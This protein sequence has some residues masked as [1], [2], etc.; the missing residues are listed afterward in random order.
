MKKQESKY[1]FILGIGLAWLA[2]I[3]LALLWVFDRIDQPKI[4]MMCSAPWQWCVPYTE[5]KEIN[6]IIRQSYL[7]E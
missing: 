3:T 2:I 4:L 5:P 7:E 6:H 1:S